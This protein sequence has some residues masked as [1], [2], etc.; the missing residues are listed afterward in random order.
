MNPEDIASGH[1]PAGFTNAQ[2]GEGFRLLDS[3]EFA[4]GVAVPRLIQIEQWDGDGWDSSEWCGACKE[5]TFR[6]RLSRA[7]LRAARGLPPEPLNPEPISHDARSSGHAKQLSER[8]LNDG[9]GIPAPLVRQ[10]M[11]ALNDGHASKPHHEILTEEAGVASRRVE[12]NAG[13]ASNPQA[14]ATSETEAADRYYMELTAI[15]QVL[16]GITPPEPMG[17]SNA[18][19]SA[20]ALT[21]ERD[22]LAVELAGANERALN[23]ER[24][25][26][27]MRRLNGLDSQE[28]RKLCSERDEARRQLAAL[29]RDSVSSVCL[30]LRC[31]L[32]KA[33]AELAEARQRIGVLERD[34]TK[35]RERCFSVE[36]QRNLAIKERDALKAQLDQCKRDLAPLKHDLGIALEQE[37]QWSE[38][39]HTSDGEL[40][41]ERLRNIKLSNDIQNISAGLA[42][43]REGSEQLAADLAQCQRERDALL[44]ALRLNTEAWVKADDDYQQQIADKSALCERL[45]A[46]VEKMYGQAERVWKEGYQRARFF[47]VSPS[48]LEE[49]WKNSDSC[50]ELL[51]RA[52][53]KP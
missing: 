8:A 53:G 43:V 50:K 20:K 36:D 2:V 38:R 14:P 29:E 24:A 19:K 28:L 40:V 32:D 5:F 12:A 44:T 9:D 6:T 37:R 47:C 31:E 17:W 48:L 10:A 16:R 30:S 21:E 18:F 51:Q 45:T 27:D 4:E 7:E 23:W 1:N 25:W 41:D 42:S 33:T 52:E 34:M 11:V 15:S 22:R 39:A 13:P 3:D 46:T 49:D 26:A 35:Y